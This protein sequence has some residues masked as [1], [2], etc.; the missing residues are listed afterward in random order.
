MEQN[1]SRYVTIVDRF[2]DG[3]RDVRLGE[4]RDMLYKRDEATNDFAPY[5]K[6]TTILDVGVEITQGEFKQWCNSDAGRSLLA[7][8]FEG[9]D[10]PE[11][12]ILEES[13]QPP[14]EAMEGTDE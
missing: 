8:Y 6:P 14:G 3:S 5:G 1:E 4:R 11:P 12:E 9:L 2:D 10:G 7:P 13:E